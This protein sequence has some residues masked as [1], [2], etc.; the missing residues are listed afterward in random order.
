MRLLIVV[1]LLAAS[2]CSLPTRKYPAHVMQ[3]YQKVPVMYLD[4]L[5]PEGERRRQLYLDEV[6]VFTLRG[7]SPYVLEAEKDVPVK[8]KLDLLEHILWRTKAPFDVV[9][10]EVG[11]R[12]ADEYYVDKITGAVNRMPSVEVRATAYRGDHERALAD[13]VQLAFTRDRSPAP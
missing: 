13:G 9:L 2:A 3:A 6:I 8:V 10:V 1:L 11:P 12:Y 5:T 7:V 4:S